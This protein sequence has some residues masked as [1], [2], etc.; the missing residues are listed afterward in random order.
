[1]KVKEEFPSEND[2]DLFLDGRQETDI[3]FDCNH[4]PDDSTL[5]TPLGRIRLIKYEEAEINIWV[6]VH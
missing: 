3:I 1:M 6:S 5:N 2:I 4:L